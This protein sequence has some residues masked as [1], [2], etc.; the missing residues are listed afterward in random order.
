MDD[1]DRGKSI[2]YRWRFTFG[3]IGFASIAAFF[4]LSEHR[5]HFLGVLPWV[6]LLLACPL[7][8][9]FMHG[10]HGRH[11]GHHAGAG[12]G[13]SPGPVRDDQPAAIDHDAHSR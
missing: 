13:S 4:M 5:A 2:F 11:G 3:F 6:L 1:I 8:H 9:M 7:L 10:G 12:G